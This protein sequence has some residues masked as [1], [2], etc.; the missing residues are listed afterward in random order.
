MLANRGT[1][2]L[3]TTYDLTVAID[4]FAKQLHVLVID[5][6]WTWTVTFDKNRVFSLGAGADSRSF[7]STAPIAHRS[8]C[9]GIRRQITGL[10]CGD[11]SSGRCPAE[12]EGRGL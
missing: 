8:W 4:Q 11:K 7:A 12:H 1:A 10:Q 5:I 9:H 6:H 3:A 2:A